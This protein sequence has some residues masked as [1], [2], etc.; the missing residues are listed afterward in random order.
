VVVLLARGEREWEMMTAGLPPAETFGTRALAAGDL[1]G[2]GWLDLVAVAEVTNPSHRGPRGLR[3]FFNLKGQGWEEEEI[4]QAHRVYGDR[5]TIG[6]VLGDGRPA[7]IV[8][9]LIQGYRD[10][11]WVREEEGWRALSSGMPENLLFW[12]VSLCDLLGNGRQELFLATG[13]A[14]TPT[15]GPRVLSLEGERWADLSAGLPILAVRNIAAGDLEGNGSCTLAVTQMRKGS[16]HLFRYSRVR[17]WE[18][19]MTLER[20]AEV[21]GLLFGLTIADVDGDGREDL[22]ANYARAPY[23]GGIQVWLS[24]PQDR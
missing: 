22:I 1:N 17:R 9:G 4:K 21:E 18:E 12:G 16:V 23:R 2:D 20:P 14:R 13:G 15:F 7:V 5:I 3:V 8:G 6:D 11:V 10:I 24:R 19:W